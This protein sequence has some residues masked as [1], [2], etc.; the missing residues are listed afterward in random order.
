[1][2]TPTVHSVCRPSR[3]CTTTPETNSETVTSNPK[4]HGCSPSDTKG[5]GNSEISNLQSP[6]SN[7]IKAL[8][9]GP[10]IGTI[11]GERISSIG[12]MSQ[13]IPS[14]LSMPGTSNRSTQRE[15]KYR[16]LINSTNGCVVSRLIT[17]IPI[18]IWISN[19]P[20][21]ATWII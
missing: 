3:T 17:L 5:N 1:M 9:L 12:S 10:P 13:K 19:K 8:S 6:I 2:R 20:G 7:R 15:W 21:R 16:S 18:S 11:V 14:D 4:K